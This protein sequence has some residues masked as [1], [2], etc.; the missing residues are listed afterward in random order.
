LNPTDLKP[1]AARRRAWLA[2]AAAGAATLLLGTLPGCGFALRHPPELQLKRVQLRGFAAL[3]SM[4]DELR[5]QLRTSPGV[6]LVERADAAEVVLEALG[7][8]REQVV[9]ASTAAGQVR[10]LT[11]RARL[12]FRAYTPSGHELIPATEL[13]LSRDM[14]YTETAAL[15]K[16]YEA[17]IMFRAMRSDLANQV[18]RRLAALTPDMARAP[19]AAAAPEGASAA[20]PADTAAS[21]APPPASGPLPAG[22]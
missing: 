15:A 17:Q 5:R 3:S 12:R 4:A 8:G 2:G 10:E 18:L 9:A 11:L 14:S 20:T 22:W 21:A 7:D 13:V 16:D 1:P 19:A 6:T